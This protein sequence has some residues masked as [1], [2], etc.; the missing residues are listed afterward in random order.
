[1]NELSNFDGIYDHA[2]ESAKE[3]IRELKRWDFTPYSKFLDKYNMDAKDVEQIQLGYVDRIEVK[4]Q[5]KNK[6]YTIYKYNK[7][8][9][10]EYMKNDETYTID[11]V[12]H[13]IIYNPYALLIQL[14]E[15]QKKYTD[16]GG[17]HMFPK[18]I[19]LIYH[20]LESNGYIT[21]FIYYILDYVDVC[22]ILDSLCYSTEATAIQVAKSLADENS[23]LYKSIINSI[24]IGLE[25]NNSIYNGTWLTKFSQKKFSLHLIGELWLDN[26][27]NHVWIP[28]VDGYGDYADCW[29]DNILF[30]INQ[31]YFRLFNVLQA[32]I[33]KGNVD[34]SI[35]NLYSGVTVD[36]IYI[37]ENPL[38]QKIKLA[39]NRQKRNI[40]SRQH[41]SSPQ[42]DIQLASDILNIDSIAAQCLEF[43]DI[44]NICD[45]NPHI[46]LNIDSL[47]TQ[48]A[49]SYKEF[50]KKYGILNVN[51][52]KYVHQNYAN[53]RVCY[54]RS[55]LNSIVYIMKHL[56]VVSLPRS[57]SIYG[58]KGLDVLVEY[59]EFANLKRI[60]NIQNDYIKKGK[61]AV[62]PNAIDLVY[63]INPNTEKSI[64]IELYC[65]MEKLDITTF[66]NLSSSD[67]L[68]SRLDEFDGTNVATD[69]IKDLYRE[70]SLLYTSL[71]TILEICNEL[72]T[73][74]RLF[75]DD[76]SGRNVPLNKKLTQFYRIDVP[77][78]YHDNNITWK[79]HI[80]NS[81]QHFYTGL[82]ICLY[83]CLQ[84]QIKSGN[85]DIQVK[86]F[87]SGVNDI[88]HIYMAD[89]EP[90]LKKKILDTIKRISNA[91]PEFGGSEREF[92]NMG[93][94]KR[95][96]LQ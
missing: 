93:L 43:N 22:N 28:R 59:S 40:D 85:V 13:E 3:Y 74:H 96:L 19:D 23:L 57:S 77:A 54:V 70:D 62:F 69:L 41:P 73:K 39:V 30:S 94:F 68:E 24:C 33:T 80:T 61:P 10:F 67:N 11:R 8:I 35:L 37:T 50:N 89:R 75:I 66:G 76:W 49:I 5:S 36:N 63:C 4:D 84:D 71:V 14:N 1:M 32:Y 58:Y 26:N 92:K 51:M 15:I 82:M 56:D 47:K 34:P 20:I 31:L 60:N 12:L 91:S 45:N 87:F 25:L 79:D 64:L 88:Q 21:I 6:T 27:L 42:Q 81:I 78:P 38:K 55:K 95:F 48:N 18:P 46:K 83:T 29:V 7:F 72:Y 53:G 9:M 52:A 17:F 90:P 65:I 44:Q 2:S 86:Q 16:I